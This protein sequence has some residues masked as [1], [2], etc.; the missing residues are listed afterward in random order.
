MKTDLALAIWDVRCVFRDA[1]RE[2]RKLWREFFPL[3]ES[4]YMREL[5]EYAALPQP[6]EWDADIFE[7]IECEPGS[8]LR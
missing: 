1:V 4:R 2:W 8:M 3:P 5:R 6:W 7:G